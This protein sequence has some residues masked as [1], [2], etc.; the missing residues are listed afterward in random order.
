M[1][2]AV[3][4]SMVFSP[5]MISARS[6]LENLGHQVILPEFTEHYAKLN[7]QDEIHNESV[8]NKMQH[9]LIK[10]HFDKI[11]DADAILVYNLTKK[12][13]EN[14]IGGNTFLE[15]GFAHVLDK[16]IFLLNS[17]PEIPAYKD[18]MEAMKPI[19]LNG[20]LVNI[21]EQIIT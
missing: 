2:I 4:G 18:E 7:S 13:I 20:D 1:K 14:Y 10:G 19:I 21:P 17:L 9:D 15:M 8:N 5:E 11:K 3:C 16:K 6:T 12:G